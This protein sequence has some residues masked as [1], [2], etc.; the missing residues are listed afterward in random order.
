M[1]NRNKPS[2]IRKIAP[3]LLT[4]VAVLVL[5][6]AGLSALNGQPAGQTATPENTAAGIIPNP[7]LNSNVTWSTF[8]NGWKA[9]EYNNGTANLTLNANPSNYYENYI[10]VNPT[11]IIAPGTLQNEKVGETYWNQTTYWVASGSLTGGTTQTIGSISS[12]G[13][14]YITDTTNTSASAANIPAIEFSIPL[15]SLPSNNPAYD[16]ITLAAELTGATITGAAEGIYFNNGSAN[17]YLPTTNVGETEYTTLSLQQIN[18][19]GTAQFNITGK[20]A[21]TNLEIGFLT[22]QPEISSTT[23]TETIYALA[24]TTTPYPLGTTIYKNATTD[25]TNSTGNAQLNTFNPSFAWQ[26]VANGGYTVAV[27]QPMQ[28]ETIS[29]AA[30][31]QNGYSEQVTYQGIE[32][33]P[34][35]PDLSYTN[36]NISMPLTI[37]GKQFEVVN[38]NG[39]SYS[40]EINAMSNGTYNFGTVNPNSQNSIILEVDYT[41]SQWNSVS[42]PPSFW[43]VQGIEYYW[44]VFLGMILGV[45]GLGAGIKQHAEGLRAPKGGK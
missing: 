33:L 36:S 29:E 22:H 40:T 30:I 14:T 21:M 5:L 31:N 13:V 19:L 7:V 35:A 28:N 6:F 3:V 24:L 4:A 8:H 41:T 44:Y 34:S 1:T 32:T 37:A 39:A 11:D 42:S 15:T 25:A 10:S 45:I 12:N 27:S 16:Y 2:K 23:Y 26:E 20:G 38:L 17:N 18:K 9:L 43:S